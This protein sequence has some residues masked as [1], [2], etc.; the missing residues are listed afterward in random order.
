MQKSLTIALLSATAILFTGSTMALAASGD[1]EARFERMMTHLDTDQSGA[2]SFEE[3][4]KSGDERFARMDVDEDGLVTPEEREAAKA[5]A[6]EE[7]EDRG[8]KKGKRSRKR[9]GKGLGE[10]RLDRVDT[11]QDGNISLAEHNAAQQQHFASLDAD[12]SGAVTSE[13]FKAQMENRR[14]QMKERRW[15]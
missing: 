1:R 9:G 7:R 2:V 15:E 12:G 10:A 4:A 5:A 13:E 6:M 14:A 11:D 3:F 8:G